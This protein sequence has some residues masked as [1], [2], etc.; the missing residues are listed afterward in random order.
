[1]VFAT[2]FQKLAS[3]LK[4]AFTMQIVIIIIIIN[5]ILMFIGAA[6]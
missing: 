3:H 2:F 5:G 6:Q 1:M 4:I